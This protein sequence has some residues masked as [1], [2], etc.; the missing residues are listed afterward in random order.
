MELDERIETV[1][2]DVREY[3]ET[4]RYHLAGAAAVGAAGTHAALTGDIDIAA[5]VAE[6]SY[7]AVEAPGTPYDMAGMSADVS[8]STADRYGFIDG[9]WDGFTLPFNAIGDLLNGSGDHTWARDGTGIASEPSGN[10]YGIGYWLSASL[11]LGSSSSA[12]SSRSSD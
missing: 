3:T 7:P 2:E 6:Q 10:W 9:L 12:A 1:Y 4:H 5:D 11:M 8:Q